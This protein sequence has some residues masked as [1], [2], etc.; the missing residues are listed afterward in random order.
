MTTKCLWR[1]ARM[2]A[3]SLVT[4]HAPPSYL[5]VPRLCRI[6]HRVWVHLRHFSRWLH[7]S[8]KE[9]VKSWWMCPESW[10]S[11]HISTD[12]PNVWNLLF[13]GREKV[14]FCSKCELLQEIEDILAINEVK[15][16]CVF[17]YTNSETVQVLV[18]PLKAKK[19]Q[20]LTSYFASFNPQTKMQKW[21][22]LS[23]A[24]SSKGAV[25]CFFLL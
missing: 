14:F 2:N 11:H 13:W 19:L 4:P 1:T 20:R 15:Q 5:V 6:T 16:L 22:S 21:L 17:Y 25:H 12:S 7:C 3:T 8:Q 24:N 18:A 9:E 10:P 23:K